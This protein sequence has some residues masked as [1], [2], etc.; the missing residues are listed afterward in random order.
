MATASKRPRGTKRILFRAA[1]GGMLLMTTIALIALLEFLASLA[2]HRPADLFFKN[3]RLNHTWVPNSAMTHSEWTKDNPDFPEPF[4]HHYNRQAWIE[5][6]DLVPEKPPNTCRIFYVGDSFTEGCV[7]MEESVASRLEAHLNG[8]QKDKG[9]HF[10]VINTGTTS[11]SPLIYYILIRHF[12]A[13]YSPDLIVINVDMTDDYDDWKYRQT[14]ICDKEGN[15]WAVP[16]RS[17]Y[18]SLYVDTA[19]GAV[20]P[21]PL[22][23]LNLFLFEKSYLYN[24]LQR[25]LFR[26]PDKR[27]FSFAGLQVEYEEESGPALYKRWAWCRHE[28]DAQT[29]RNVQRSMETLARIADFCNQKGIKLLLTGVPHY[30]QVTPDDSGRTEWSLRPHRE[31]ERCAREKGVAYLDSPASLTPLFRGTPQH[32]YYYRGDIHLN[33]R[34]NRLWAEAHIRAILDPKNHLLPTVGP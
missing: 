28:W 21:N 3:H 23:K 32:H 5:D 25:R 1:L 29:E 33:P 13:P 26:P 2:I 7:P 4:R 31:I 9:L 24:Y 20:R 10:E 12:I 22:M 8:A 18:E 19:K 30:Q 27:D 16:P 17:I 15:P 11:Y 6:Y 14:L 34:G